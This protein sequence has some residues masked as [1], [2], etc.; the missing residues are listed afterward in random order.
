MLLVETAG[1]VAAVM[2][3]GRNMDRADTMPIFLRMWCC[4]AGGLSDI[5]LGFLGNEPTQKALFSFVVVVQ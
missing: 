5:L 4:S 1:R 2:S 3:E